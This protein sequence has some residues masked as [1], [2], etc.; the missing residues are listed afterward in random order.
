MDVE[1]ARGELRAFA[2]MT[3]MRNG[4]F[5]TQDYTASPDGE[6]AAAASAIEQI[7]DRVIPTG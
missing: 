2:R 3:V 1:W 7:L 5:T 4:S 6:V